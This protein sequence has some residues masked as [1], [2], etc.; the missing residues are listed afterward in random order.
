[1]SS[2]NIVK[3]SFN[4][5]TGNDKIFVIGAGPIS[6]VLNADN[7]IRV[8]SKDGRLDA[9]FRDYESGPTAVPNLK[10]AREQSK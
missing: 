8:T 7:S 2:G 9:T 1:M 5:G 3:G 6:Q 4:G 10:A